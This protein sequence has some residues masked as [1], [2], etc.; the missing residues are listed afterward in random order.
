M[1]ILEIKNLIKRFEGVQAIDGLSIDIEKGLITSI[2]GPN[3]SGK[4]TLINALSGM[5]E[6]DGGHLIIDGIKIVYYIFK[7]RL[8]KW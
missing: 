1:K 5:V 8:A 6:I 4:T 7:W 3:G 2:I